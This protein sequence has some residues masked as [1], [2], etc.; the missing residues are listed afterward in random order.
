MYLKKKNVNIT[1]QPDEIM[2][3]LMGRARDVVRK[4]IRSDSSLSAEQQPDAIYT[5]LKQHF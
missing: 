3:K 5:I 2:G 1:N 4:G